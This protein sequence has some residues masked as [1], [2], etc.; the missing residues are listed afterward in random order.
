MEGL[1]N[2][3]YCEEQEACRTAYDS[4]G[5]IGRPVGLR[6]RQIGR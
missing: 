4:L 3:Q 1:K 5:G 6:R 2:E